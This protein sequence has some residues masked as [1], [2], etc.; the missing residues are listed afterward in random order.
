VATG[1]GQDHVAEGG[2]EQ[3]EEAASGN[4]MD[5]AL[6]PEVG[7]TVPDAADPIE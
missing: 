5:G 6:N 4:E 1:S 3:P 2:I 7:Q